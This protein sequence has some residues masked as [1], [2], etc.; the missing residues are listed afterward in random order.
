MS[1]S[2]FLH[3]F[4]APSIAGYGFQTIIRSRGKGASLGTILAAYFR[5]D[6]AGSFAPFH[7]RGRES[8]KVPR[9][10]SFGRFRPDC[11]GQAMHESVQKGAGG[12]ENGV[13]TLQGTIHLRIR[14]HHGSLC[15]SGIRI[16]EEN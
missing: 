7:L 8:A 13:K 14:P 10:A 16:G 15:S 11:F 2:C 12:L 9:L 3:P 6:T 4:P 5:L 1:F